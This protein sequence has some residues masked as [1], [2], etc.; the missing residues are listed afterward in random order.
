M[1]RAEAPLSQE[2]GRR[3]DARAALALP[4]GGALRAALAATS[5]SARPLEQGT[6][7]SETRRDPGGGAAAPSGKPKHSAARRMV[8]AAQ[9]EAAMISAYMLAQHASRGSV[10]Q[11]QGLGSQEQGVQ[12][13]WLPTAAPEDTA[14][15]AAAAG[16]R[17]APAQQP[18]QRRQLC[19]CWC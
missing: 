16:A 11:G 18:R 6:P 4:S 8:E 10:A 3:A 15:G 13:A 19:C 12:Y 14:R 17:S 9:R 1:C 7:G 2:E 5:A